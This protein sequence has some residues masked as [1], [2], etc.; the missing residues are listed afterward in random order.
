MKFTRSHSTMCS[1]T[2]REFFNVSF[3]TS[4]VEAWFKIRYDAVS[5]ECRFI[6]RFSANV[7]SAF[8][9][10]LKL[11]R[12]SGFF[13]S[14]SVR[15]DSAWEPLAQRFCRVQWYSRNWFLR[16]SLHFFPEFFHFENFK[17]SRW[18]FTQIICDTPVVLFPYDDKTASVA[19]CRGSW[20]WVNV[21]GKK[22]IQKK[23]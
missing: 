19:K 15:P 21:V 14:L 8:F 13:F 1:C 11:L 4:L 6:N 12:Q 2:Q 7:T 23:D 10:R 22:S 16:P 18:H 9:L 5:F 3:V 17:T 20:V